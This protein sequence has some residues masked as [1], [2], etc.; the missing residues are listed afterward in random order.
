MQNFNQHCSVSISTF[1]VTVLF[2]VGKGSDRRPIILLIGVWHILL[3]EKFR[4]RFEKIKCHA[5][6]KYITRE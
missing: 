6:L 2:R 3:I 5:F 4:W 1:K